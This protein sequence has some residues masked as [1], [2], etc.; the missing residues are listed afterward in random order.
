MKNKNNN[1]EKKNKS[2]SIEVML[3]KCT[4]RDAGDEE[5]ELEEKEVQQASIHRG[6]IRGVCVE[7]ETQ[8]MK[9]NINERK[10]NNNKTAS[11]ELMLEECVYRETQQMK[12]KN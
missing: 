7:N 5:Q 10:K 8:Q 4:E 2:V 9:N 12:N 6:Y 1:K 3:D 11:M